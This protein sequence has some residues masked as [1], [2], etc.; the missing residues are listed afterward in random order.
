[1]ATERRGDAAV[2]ASCSLLDS[3][4]SEHAENDAALEDL[5]L[6]NAPGISLC[7]QTA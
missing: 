4:L 6:T 1:M 5:G 7:G 3:N 2:R